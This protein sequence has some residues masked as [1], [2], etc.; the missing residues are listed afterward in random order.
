MGLL[1]DLIESIR[2]PKSKQVFFRSLN[3]NRQI[4][5]WYARKLVK[6]DS[7][8]EPVSNLEKVD[9]L[10]KGK[11]RV[12]FI[13]NHL[14][15]ADSHI[16]ETLF[17]RFGFTDLA[18]HI[19][20]IAGQKTFDLSRRLFTRSMNTIR[21]YQPKARVEK[22]IK[23][24][25]NTKAL[26]WA[27]HLRHRGYSVLVFP[28]GTRT[29]RHKRFNPGAANPK[30]TIYFRHSLVVPLG[31]MGPEN[32]MPVGRVLQTPATVRLRVGE[33]MDHDRLQESIQG[34]YAEISEH[35]LRQKMMSH[36]MTQINDLLDTEYRAQE[37]SVYLE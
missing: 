23:K 20:H 22:A 29:R 33:P 17:M 1:L 14:T 24:Q 4:I 9:Q 28:E 35:D 6:P 21:V 16:I 3:W 30:A 18:N 31:L 2:K 25:M 7:I 36:Y 15:Y 12:T 8:I 10:R 34:E 27:A 5:F 19:I 26:K 11:T 32:I 37:H 13:C